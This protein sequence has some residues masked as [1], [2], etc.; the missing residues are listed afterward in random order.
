MTAASSEDLATHQ[1]ALRVRGEFIEMPGLRL[2]LRQAQRLWGL[3]SS[4]CEAILNSLV[5]VG[6]LTRTRDQAFALRRNQA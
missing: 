6:F 3:E 4:Y 5:A 1:L 2:N